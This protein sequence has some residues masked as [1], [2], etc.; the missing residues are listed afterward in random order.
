MNKVPGAPLSKSNK[1]EEL[2]EA[3]KGDSVNSICDKKKALDENKTSTAS[4]QCERP[5]S[6][7]V[8]FGVVPKGS[9]DKLLEENSSSENKSNNTHSRQSSGTCC[10]SSSGFSDTR[11]GDIGN[12]V[13]GSIVGLHRKMVSNIM[14]LQ[15]CHFRLL[16][17][18]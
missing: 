5:T 4:D 8:G 11:Y 9:A 7:D 3:P 2:I 16:F 1:K 10:T 18:A 6:S 12:C 17:E 13:Q 15:I 14:I